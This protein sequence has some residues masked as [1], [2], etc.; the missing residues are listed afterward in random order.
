MTV[1]YRIT[2]N[3]QFHDVSIITDR[4]KNV[5]LRKCSRRVSG[6][7]IVKKNGVPGIVQRRRL[8][9]DSAW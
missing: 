7:A 5:A 9:N 4:V 3:N 6:A 1:V 2:G 8:G